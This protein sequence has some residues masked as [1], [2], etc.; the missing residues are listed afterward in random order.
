MVLTLVEMI[1][2]GS[3]VNIINKFG[4]IMNSNYRG[5]NVNAH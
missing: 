2:C 1:L 5:V 3:L 4:V